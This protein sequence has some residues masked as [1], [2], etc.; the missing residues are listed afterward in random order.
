MN[1]RTV[2]RAVAT[3]PIA[4]A[5]APL[6]A[7]AQVG[8]ENPVVQ[9]PIDINA[10]IALW[11]IILGFISTVIVSAI[12]RAWPDDPTKKGLA[13]FLFCLMVA[14]ADTFIR[15]TFN[16]TNLV[17]TFLVVFAS[18][19]LFYRQFFQTTQMA[20]KLEGRG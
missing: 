20:A 13:A 6:I 11:L 9:Y 19:V 8:G 4:L 5:L 14:I 2:V 10:Q 1:R 18:A 12:N 7:L 15:Q 17:A 3:A 16:P